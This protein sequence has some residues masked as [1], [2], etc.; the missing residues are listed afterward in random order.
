MQWYEQLLKKKGANFVRVE[1]SK[2]H[3]FPTLSALF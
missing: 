2:G 3:A 1:K